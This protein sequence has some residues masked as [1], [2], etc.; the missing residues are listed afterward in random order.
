MTLLGQH[1]M[2]LGHRPAF[3]EPPVANLD[4]DPQRKTAAAQR[5]GFGF[6]GG[7]HAFLLRFRTLRITAPIANADDQIAPMQKD[8]IL[9]PQRIRALQ[10]AMAAWTAGA[11][12]PIVVL[13]NFAI[14]FGSSHR[15]ASLALGS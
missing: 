14:V 15:P 9:S 6:L 11:F 4:D 2:N 7:K 12:G 5:Q 10:H 1:F 13:G 8:N 3:P